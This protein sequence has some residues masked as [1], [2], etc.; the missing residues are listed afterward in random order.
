MLQEKFNFFIYLTVQV[1]DVI[2]VH[3]CTRM[4]TIERECNRKQTLDHSFVR[5]SV[6]RLGDLLDF[7]QL[8]KAFGNN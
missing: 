6:T 4:H 8:F 3:Y 2:H 7:G 1:V 5:F